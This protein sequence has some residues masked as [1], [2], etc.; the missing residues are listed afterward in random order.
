MKSIVLLVYSKCTV[1]GS[2][3]LG[4]KTQRDKESRKNDY[5]E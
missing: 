1:N 5:C 4:H 2:Y 3:I